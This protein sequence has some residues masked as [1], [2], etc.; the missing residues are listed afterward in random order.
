MYQSILVEHL[1]CYSLAILLL[2]TDRKI[3]MEGGPK[4]RT[5]DLYITVEFP[6]VS[7]FSHISLSASQGVESSKANNI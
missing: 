3:S 4:W 5:I 6:L 7:F 1:K 2:Q